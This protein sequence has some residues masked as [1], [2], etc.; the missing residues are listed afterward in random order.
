MNDEYYSKVHDVLIQMDPKEHHDYNR[1]IINKIREIALCS[2]MFL[3]I[4]LIYGRHYEWWIL[5]QA[6][7]CVNPNKSQGAS[8]L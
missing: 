3:K 1:T 2:K 4:K 5:F 7:G 8:W 6:I